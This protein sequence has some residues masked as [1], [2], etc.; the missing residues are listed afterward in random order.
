VLIA[1]GER[2]SIAFI[3]IPRQEHSPL[4]KSL[5]VPDAMRTLLYPISKLAAP[6]VINSFIA[7][8]PEHAT[9]STVSKKHFKVRNTENVGAQIV[10]H[11]YLIMNQRRDERIGVSVRNVIQIK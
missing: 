10:F 4:M 1:K 8:L 3:R 7:K 11:H 9:A 5:S 6:V 2:R